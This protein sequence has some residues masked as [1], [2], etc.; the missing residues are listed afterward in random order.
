MT[1]D[2]LGFYGFE[3]GLDNRV[4]ETATL[5]AHRDMEAVSFQQAL[6]FVRAI[7]AASVSVVDASRRRLAQ[8]DGQ[9]QCPD[10]QIFLQ[11]VTDCPADDAT[12]I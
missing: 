5:A 1:P 9:F 2:Q 8:I 7:L 12:G 11:A 4:V 3:E 10:R 6:I